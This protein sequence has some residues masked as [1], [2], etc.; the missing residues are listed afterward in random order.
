MFCFPVS[1]LG[2]LILSSLRIICDSSDDQITINI[3]FFSSSSS[4]FSHIYVPFV[5][6]ET[7]NAVS[8]NGRTKNQEVIVA[9]VVVVVVVLLEGSHL[10]VRVVKILGTGRETVP[11]SN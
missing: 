8:S 10:F 11:K 1:P 3:V 5:L 9:V 2:L 7:C 4:L 6:L